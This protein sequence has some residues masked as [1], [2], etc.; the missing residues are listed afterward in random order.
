MT[1]ASSSGFSAF[2]TSPS[3]HID[4]A[5]RQRHR[6][7]LAAPDDAGVQGHRQARPHL[8]LATGRRAPLPSS[9]PLGH[10]FATAGCRRVRASRAPAGRPLRPACVRR[11]VALG[12]NP[13]GECGY[14][15]IAHE[16]ERTAA[17]APRDDPAPAARLSHPERSTGTKGHRSL[18]QAPDPALRAARAFALTRPRRSTPSRAAT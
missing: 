8:Q 12:G 7:G 13:V 10:H 16:E 14:P 3:E 9:S 11:I 4:A 6:V 18:P 17:D 15:K 1:P 2:S 5:A